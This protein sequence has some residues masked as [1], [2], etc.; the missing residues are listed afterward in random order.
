MGF[1]EVS[2]VEAVGRTDN[3][4]KE[5]ERAVGE[6]D[7]AHQASQYCCTRVH[8]AR[9]DITYH[10]RTLGWEEEHPVGY[11]DGSQGEVEGCTV[12]DL[13]CFEHE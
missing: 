10:S 4:A 9:E 5:V 13:G 11:K 3:A 2:S 7:V 1:A 6:E 8:N 12:E